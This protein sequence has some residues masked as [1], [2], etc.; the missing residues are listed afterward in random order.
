VAIR[1]IQHAFAIADDLSRYRGNWV[2]IRD[3][4]VVA[5][6]I[7]PVELRNNPDVH[8]DDLYLLVPSELDGSFLL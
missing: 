4:K 6:A 2:A 1:E 8:S 5:V 7:D 3:G